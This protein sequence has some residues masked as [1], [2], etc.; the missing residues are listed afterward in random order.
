[1]TTLGGAD[2]TTCP[3]SQK[4]LLNSPCLN[5]ARGLPSLG[6]WEDR[7]GR[8]LVAD[9]GKPGQIQANN[10]RMEPK[11]IEDGL[12]AG[13]CGKGQIRTTPNSFDSLLY[14]LP[15]SLCSTLAFSKQPSAY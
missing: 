8:G 5:K 4:V 3:A 2:Y 10:F 9:T 15:T 13:V 1:M 11:S 7:E 12:D 6:R 14:R